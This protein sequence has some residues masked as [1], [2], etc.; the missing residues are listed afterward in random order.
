[1]G[2]FPTKGGV[3]LYRGAMFRILSVLIIS[4]LAGFAY[5]QDTIDESLFSLSLAELLQVKVISLNRV[6][7]SLFKAPAALYVITRQDIERSAA[8]QIS[9]LFQRV[10]GMTVRQLSRHRHAISIRKDAQLYFSDYLVLVDNQSYYSPI[11]HSTTWEA[12]DLVLEDIERIEILRGSPGITYG[13]NSATGVI[14][15]ITRKS[16]LNEGAYVRLGAG[17]NHRRESV[18]RLVNNSEKFSARLTVMDERDR[19]Y[20]ASNTQA[21]QSDR[22]ILSL[23]MDTQWRTWDYLLNYRRQFISRTDTSL[24]TGQPVHSNSESEILYL[25]A[26]K[27]L[28]N[29]AQ[30]SVRVS[31]SDYNLVFGTIGQFFDYQLRDFES[32]VTQP[33]SWGTSQ[34]GVSWRSFDFHTYGNPAIHYT[35]NEDILNWYALWLNHSHM[36]TTDLNLSLGGRWESYDIIDDKQ[37][38]SSSLRLS[39][40]VNEQVQSWWSLSS[41]WQYPS[42]SQIN[43]NATVG[44]QTTPVPAVIIQSGRRDLDPEKIIDIQLGMRWQVSDDMNIEMSAFQSRQTGQVFVNP[45]NTQLTAGDP[46]GVLNV[47]FDNIIDSTSQGVELVGRYYSD[48][49]WNSEV[50]G[51]YIHTRLTADNNLKINGQG[52]Y[53]DSKL[54]WILGFEEVWGGTLQTEFSWESAHHSENA[55]GL[56]ADPS[57]FTKIDEVYRLDL[58][59]HKTINSNV[60]SYLNIKNLFNHQVNWNYPFGTTPAQEVEA[61]ITVGI[62]VIF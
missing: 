52:Y 17:N 4:S 33:W 28:K 18:A 60:S 24:F 36:L 31:A 51:S 41:I 53:P 58:A 3:S 32:I 10:P 54:V 42:I 11:I 29:D 57:S 59:Y 19:G 14:N 46:L 6:E 5:P 21:D 13:A 12:V 40:A 50:N 2:K 45:N 56:F 61:S 9:D 30:V 8:E 55:L 48:N 43:S 49:G 44:T 62:K 37:S 15:I 25:N 20:D 22:Q 16:H 1:M 23:R 27:T 38:F 26:S 47:Y 35:P 7:E 34:V 39:Y